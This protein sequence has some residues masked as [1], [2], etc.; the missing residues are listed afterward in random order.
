MNL[1]HGVKEV[2]SY[3]L[4][5]KAFKGQIH[6]KMMEWG[7]NTIHWTFIVTTGLDG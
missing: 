2:V 1:L 4:M 6:T 7:D 3:I 5:I